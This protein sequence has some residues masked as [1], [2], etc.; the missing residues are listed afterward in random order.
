M[1]RGTSGCAS[2]SRN[3]SAKNQ[4][5]GSKGA[6]LASLRVAA[7]ERLRD[8]I[9]IVDGSLRDDE[10]IGEAMPHQ[11]PAAV[12][13]ERR[14][15]RIVRR[16]E[17]RGLIDS[18]GARPVPDLRFVTYRRSWLADWDPHCRRC[19]SAPSGTGKAA[20]CARLPWT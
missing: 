4:M 1:I 16:H 17:R 11:D 18:S 9:A 13:A 2:S 3:S 20:V 7:A 14:Q 19:T 8:S 5:S 15:V 12:I 10:L 6:R